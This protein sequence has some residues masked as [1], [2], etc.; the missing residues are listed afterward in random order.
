MQPGKRRALPETPDGRLQKMIETVKAHIRSKVE[1]QYCV[2][3]QQF[4]FQKTG[5][6]G[7]YL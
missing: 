4:D 1:H 7:N 2:I 5:Q 6:R 3:K